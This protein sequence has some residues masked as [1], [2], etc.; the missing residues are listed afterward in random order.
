MHWALN[1]LREEH[2]ASAVEYAVLLALI[3]M[4]II[5]SVASVGQGTGGMWSGNKAAFESVGFGS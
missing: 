4:A 2:A 3:L 1:F 5:A